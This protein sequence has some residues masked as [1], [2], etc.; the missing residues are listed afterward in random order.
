MIVEGCEAGGKV[1]LCGEHFVLFGARALAL[2]W[3][4]GRLR[5]RPADGAAP[6]APGDDARLL[7]AWNRARE[8][9]GLSPAGACPFAVEST[10]PPGAGLGSSAALSVVLVR[11][12]LAEAGA[13]L[14]DDGLV[15]A[16]TAVEAVFHGRSS[17]L[18][19]A[20]IVRGRPVLRLPDGSLVPAPWRLPPLALV[21]ALA[22]GRRRTA[23]AVEQVQR[24]AAAS[25]AFFRDLRDE[26]DGLAGRA[27]DLMGA[28]GDDGAAALGALL[29]RNHA[30]LARAGVSTPLLDRLV[31]A[32]R[33][34]GS[35]GAKLCGA[36][37]GGV[38][39]ALPAP[40]REKAVQ[41]ALAG[42]GAERVMA[43]DVR[44][45]GEP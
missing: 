15:A 23:E 27:A 22:P 3:S 11:A 31:A 26:A 37:L 8:R 28:G 29:F 10:I 16:A 34:A 24:L 42:A 17:G 2:P 9:A 30:L 14:A 7:A 5:L 41:A 40:G 19:P 32:A 6:V 35:L 12:A 13:V 36:G 1:T 44:P 20:A 25:P 38:V 45:E 4:G 33:E 21:L 18:D 43:W 39:L